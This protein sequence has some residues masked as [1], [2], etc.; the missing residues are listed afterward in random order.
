M[1]KM[2]ERHHDMVT[3]GEL[4]GRP[5]TPILRR[6]PDE[7]Q[8]DA[9]KAERCAYELRTSVADLTEQFATPEGK[10][11]IKASQEDIAA[12]YRQLGVLVR[13]LERE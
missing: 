12:S 6:Q 13:A 7:H 10:G 11:W 8:Q 1:G 4:L 9:I 3:L 5:Y 2:S